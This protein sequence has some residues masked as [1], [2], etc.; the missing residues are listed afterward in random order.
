MK[1]PTLEQKLIA[2][3]AGQTGSVQFTDR[4]MAAIKHHEIISDVVR[5]TNVKPKETFI[6]KLRQLHTPAIIAI[7]IALTFAAAGTAYAIYA[8]W[9]KPTVETT[10]SKP[11]TEGR[12][13]IAAQMKDCEDAGTTEKSYEIKKN[14]QL[15]AKQAA[16]TI[17]GMCEMDAIQSWVKKQPEAFY[18]PP[19]SPDQD[20]DS[21]NGFHVSKIE[22]IKDNEITLSSAYFAHAHTSNLT[23][24]EETKI[25]VNSAYG[26]KSDLKPGDRIMPVIKATYKPQAT[27]PHKE[28][29]LYIFKMELP[30]EAYEHKAQQSLAERTPCMGNVDDTCVNSSAIPILAMQPAR[31]LRPEGSTFHELQGKL[32]SM[33]A[34]GFAVQGSSG[35]TV[36]FAMGRDVIADFHQNR[37]KNYPGM[38][39]KL[40]DMMKIT[41][42]SPPEDD[43]TVA[44][45]QYV[46]DIYLMTETVNKM[47]ASKKY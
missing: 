33:D 30:L 23:L 22:S 24:Q 43:G 11:N 4:V 44:Q 39:V 27:M 29:L 19:T 13:E 20:S 3:T 8:L 25:I 35:R 41:Y 40:G 34:T 15:S 46:A 9:P 12:I 28:R 36:T 7:A 21:L 6:M 5:K 38:T 31:Q 47:D 42:Y 17:Q 26:K 18:R 45:G 37:A 16:Q 1:K 2:A 10:I 32:V 14:S